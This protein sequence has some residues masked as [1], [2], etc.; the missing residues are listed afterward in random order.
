[1][2]DHIF[3]SHSSKED[4]F[5]KQLRQ[6]LELHGQVPWVDSRELTAGDDLKARIEESIRTARHFLVVISLDALNSE[7]VECELDI[8]L[9]E[10]EQRE[11]GYKVIPVVLPRTPMRIFK[12]FFPG[13][14]LYIEVADAPNGLSEALPAIFAA[15]GLELPTD[16]QGKENVAAKPLAELLLKLTD[17]QI[18]E[19]DD[20]RRATAMAELEYIPADKTGRSILSRRYRFTAPLGPVELEELRWYIERYFLWPVGVF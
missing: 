6:V 8:A 5:V 14:P 15:L 20:I 2:S 19:E 18:K 3:I 16:W 10:A 7:W 9:N 13:D 11:D 17:P 4:N 12:R 1:M